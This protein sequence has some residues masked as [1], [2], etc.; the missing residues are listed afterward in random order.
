MMLYV[1]KSRWKAAAVF[2]KL[3]HAFQYTSVVTL[4]FRPRPCVPGSKPITT[5]T[6]ATYTFTRKKRQ[7]QPLIYRFVWHKFN[8][9]ILRI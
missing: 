6:D 9:K 1:I 5:S 7:F 8:G 4:P 2:V 3:D